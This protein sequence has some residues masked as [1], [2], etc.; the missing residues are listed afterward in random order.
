M[1]GVASCDKLRVGA[2]SLRSEDTLMGLPT[3]KL[4]LFSASFWKREPSGVK[5]LSRRRKKNQL[6]FPY[7]RRAKRDLAQTESAM[8]TQQ[9]CGVV[10]NFEYFINL[11]EIIW[12][13]LMQRVI[14]PQTNDVKTLLLTRV[15]G[16]D[17]GQGRWGITASKA[18]YLSSPIVQQY[19]EGMLKSSPEGV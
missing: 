15:P 12:N 1:K 11:V 18:K 6:R 2:C 13:D 10:V 14:S 8:V 17:N 9:R 7:Q 5:H 4:R 3:K 19:C 16:L